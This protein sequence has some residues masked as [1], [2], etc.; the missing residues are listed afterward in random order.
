[1]KSRFER[2]M[3]AGLVAVFLASGGKSATRIGSVYVEH[4]DELRRQC[5]RAA[6]LYEAPALEALPKLL[7]ARIPG[8]A[9]LDN[10]QPVAMHLVDSGAGAP[11]IVLELAAATTPEA[12]L[13]GLVGDGVPL[14]ATDGGLYQLADGTSAQI[15]GKR[16]FLTPGMAT[17][18][19]VLVKS[20]VDARPEMPVLPGAIRITLLPAALIPM[21][22][23]A[24]RSLD[25]LPANLPDAE[26]H[27][28]AMRDMLDFYKRILGQLDALHLGVAVQNEG[29]FIR[30]RLVPRIGTEMAALIASMQ[31]V[32]DAQLAFLDKASLLSY[33]S[34]RAVMPDTLKQGFIKLYTRMLALSPVAKGMPAGESAALMTQSMRTMGLPTALAVGLTPDDRALRVQGMM[35]MT[36]AAAYLDEYFALLRKPEF[37]QLSGMTFTEPVAR[38]HQG[39]RILTCRGMLDEKA[40]ETMLQGAAPGAAPGQLDAS[41]RT[42]M[43]LL[44][45]VMQLFSNDLAY[46]ATPAA[47]AFGMGPPA[48]IEQAI[49]RLQGAAT[50]EAARIRSVL[51][52]TT[53]PYS[54]GRLSLAGMIRGIL[55]NLPSGEGPGDLPPVAVAQEHEGIVFGSWRSGS[56]AL[57][58]L[59]LP[60]SEVKALKTQ[61]PAVIMRGRR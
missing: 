36:N 8:G 38:M 12:Y 55:K 27:R 49:A 51:A 23:E 11:G 52:P 30:S 1:M 60:P 39:T 4:V 25:N 9:G 28:A 19:G 24:G 61:L 20:L 37:R 47:L 43:G 26:A 50:P 3:L 17:G 13:Q 18:G 21:L 46:A 6:A 45:P 2:T 53:A 29:L 32:Q 34:G 57:S 59:H 33:A 5:S 44:R 14:P 58:A 54:I 10:S 42:A 40:L 22:D 16:L 56:E 31:P 48:T 15:A 41:L 35:Q 7:A